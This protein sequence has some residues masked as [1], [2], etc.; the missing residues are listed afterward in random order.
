MDNIS[1]CKNIQFKNKQTHV[2][3]HYHAT[4]LTNNMSDK[5]RWTSWEKKKK[6]LTQFASALAEEDYSCRLYV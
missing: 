3:S 4:Q 2:T 5:S 6:S 1:W